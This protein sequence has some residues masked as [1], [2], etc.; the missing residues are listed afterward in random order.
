MKTPLAERALTAS[1]M[2]DAFLFGACAGTSTL[3]A[4]PPSRVKAAIKL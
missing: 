1:T 2:S 3:K 4:F